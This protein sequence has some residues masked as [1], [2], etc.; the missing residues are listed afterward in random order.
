MVTAIAAPLLLWYL[1]TNLVTTPAPIEQPL[2][3]VRVGFPIGRVG[4]RRENVNWRGASQIAAVRDVAIGPSRHFAAAQQTVAFGG[5]SGHQLKGAGL[6]TT[7][8]R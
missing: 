6:G 7:G 4:A 3:R 5:R 2:P 1:R 8:S